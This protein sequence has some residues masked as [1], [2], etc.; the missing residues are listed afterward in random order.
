V[1]FLKQTHKKQREMLP[2]DAMVDA[3]WAQWGGHCVI[4]G[5]SGHVLTA[6]GVGRQRHHAQMYSEH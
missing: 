1:L 4:C 5:L 2:E 3:V 6:R